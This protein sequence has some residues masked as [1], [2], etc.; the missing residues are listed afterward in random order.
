MK[1]K[2]ISF[3]DV[4]LDRILEMAWE[5]RTTFD[6]IELQFNLSEAD[7]KVELIPYLRLKA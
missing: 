2:K 7:V 3:S 1:N 4:E 5:D 6:T